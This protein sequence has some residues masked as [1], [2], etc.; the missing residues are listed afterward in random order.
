MNAK[1]PCFICSQANSQIKSSGLATPN[2]ALLVKG[3]SNWKDA[4]VKFCNHEFNKM[5]QRGRPKDG[6]SAFHDH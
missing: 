5:P 6:H 2:S 4:T 1:V 3:F